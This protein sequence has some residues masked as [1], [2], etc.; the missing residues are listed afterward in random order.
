MLKKSYKPLIKVIGLNNSNGIS[1][2]KFPEDSDSDEEIE[3]KL[4]KLN[5]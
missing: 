1:F 5:F 2:L 3:N 4:K